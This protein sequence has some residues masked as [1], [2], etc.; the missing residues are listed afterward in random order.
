MR[1]GIVWV[2]LL[3]FCQS[4]VLGQN[5]GIPGFMY[6]IDFKKHPG[7]LVLKN[8]QSIH[9]IFQYANLGFPS[10]YFKCFSESGKLLA[11]YKENE[12][13]SLT[14]AGS[15]TSLSKKDSTYFVN[16]GKSSLYRQLT[17]GDILIFDPLINVDERSGL[18]Y[19]DL[20][21]LETGGKKNIYTDKQVLRWIEKKLKQKKIEKSFK[22]IRDAIKYLNDLVA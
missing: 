1:R 6:E 8:G 2:T 12:I 17:F 9:G 4:F 10:N 11:R 19:A 5:L 22:T 3:L 20:L 14:L 18:L 16:L 15:D 7:H 21:V 13:K